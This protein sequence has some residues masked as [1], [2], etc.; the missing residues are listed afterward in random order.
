MGRL[1]RNL[2][3][4]FLSG[5]WAKSRFKF[6]A[7]LLLAFAFGSR[8]AIGMARDIASG[9]ELPAVGAGLLLAAGTLLLTYFAARSRRDRVLEPPPRRPWPRLWANAAVV[10]VFL[11]VLTFLMLTIDIGSLSRFGDA[12]RVDAT[13]TGIVAQDPNRIYEVELDRPL[14][15]IRGGT[16]LRF[17]GAPE[18][19]TCL[20]FDS[21][22]GTLNPGDRTNVL[23][24]PEREEAFLSGEE[25]QND[26]LIE[27][28]NNV[29]LWLAFVVY[30]VWAVEAL[31]RNRRAPQPQREDDTGEDEPTSG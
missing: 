24:I 2:V 21:L 14:P 7:A 15:P 26:E 18:R 22:L 9:R 4:R 27:A 17:C 10:A 29:G 19:V 20:H 1:V 16:A 6:G 25:W 3:G 5:D 28:S 13:V 11:G 30:L 23:Y 12:E 8:L 31:L